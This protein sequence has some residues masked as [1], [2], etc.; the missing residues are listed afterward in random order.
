[1]ATDNQIQ[2][3]IDSLTIGEKDGIRAQ[4]IKD[5]FQALKSRNLFSG[6]YN[7]L[8]GKPSL[9]SKNYVD[10]LNIPETI[11]HANNYRARTFLF[12]GEEEKLIQDHE[13]WHSGAQIMA[14]RSTTMNIIIYPSELKQNFET[15]IDQ[16]GEGGLNFINAEPDDYT[17]LIQDGKIPQTQNRMDSVSILIWKTFIIIKGD[18][19]DV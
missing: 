10:L 14:D 4:D 6:S 15:F 17:I 8:S 9:F 1:M 3:L 13:T 16:I 18:L 7:D 19:K 2:S 11:E 12:T 5:L